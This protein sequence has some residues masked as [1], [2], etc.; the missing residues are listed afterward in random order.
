M[1]RC[2]ECNTVVGRVVQPETE[3]VEKCPTCGCC[4]DKYYEFARC[5]QWISVILLERRAWLHVIFNKRELGPVLLLTALLSCPLEA[6]AVRTASVYAALRLDGRTPRLRELANM[7][8]VENFRLVQNLHPDMS[9]VMLYSATWP[10]LLLYACAEYLLIASVVVSFGIFVRLAGG[11]GAWRDAAVVWA[12]C[13]NLVHIA[14][15]GLVVFLVWRIPMFLAPLVDIVACL[16]ALRGFSVLTTRHSSFVGVI[17][18]FLCIST[19]IAFRHIT[20]WGP[21]LVF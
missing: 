16:W 11:A 19:R 15:L 9:S 10:T 3:S 21:Q 18:T 13:V 17:G 7:S 12:T 14:K 4:C 2:I 20:Q 1:P 6:Y 8:A 5:Q